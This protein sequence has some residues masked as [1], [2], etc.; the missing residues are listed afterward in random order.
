MQIRNKD[1]KLYLKTEKN[2]KFFENLD[3]VKGW[4]LSAPGRLPD[5]ASRSGS[6]ARP[7]PLV[8]AWSRDC[9]LPGREDRSGSTAR[10]LPLVRPWSRDSNLAHEPFTNHTW[11]E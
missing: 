9:N 5:P 10:P 2:W 6:T 4:P 1:F 7:L 11:K 3:L 8:R